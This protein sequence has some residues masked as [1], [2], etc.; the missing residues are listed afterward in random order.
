ML[1]IALLRGMALEHTCYYQAID[2]VRLI[3]GPPAYHEQIGVKNENHVHPAEHV[4]RPF[5]GRDGA[6]VFR[7][8]QITDPLEHRCFAV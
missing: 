6:I 1:S 7:H 5:F 2:T 4:Q 3:A 8:T